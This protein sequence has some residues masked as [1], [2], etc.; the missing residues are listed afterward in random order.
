ML[1]G[2]RGCFSAIKKLKGIKK[3]KLLVIKIYLHYVKYSIGNI[4]NDIVITHMVQMPTRL[5]K[6]VT[7]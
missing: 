2:G 1:T 3:Y 7:S 6:G 5:I 4:V